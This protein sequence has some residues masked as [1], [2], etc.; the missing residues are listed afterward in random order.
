MSAAAAAQ[1]ASA[2]QRV[3]MHAQ[4]RLE[5]GHA[6]AV[7]T[8]NGG[9]ATANGHC[10]NGHAAIGELPP[11]PPPP[12]SAAS[13]SISSGSEL[14]ENGGCGH[15]VAAVA[16]ALGQTHLGGGGCCH[17][18]SIVN[19][20]PSGSGCGSTELPNGSS[21]TLN[22]GS[23]AH[24]AAE[25][26]GNLIIANGTSS[27]SG[28]SSS[29]RNQVESAAPVL[30]ATTQAAAAAYWSTAALAQQNGVLPPR[31]HSIY[32]QQHPEMLN[33][34]A[35]SGSGISITAVTIDDQMKHVDRIAKVSV[36]LRWPQGT[37]AGQC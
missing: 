18:G 3:T 2:A 30:S 16:A 26:C 31:K 20:H 19:G 13:G 5:N 25:H 6:A 15:G 32:A 1:Q 35:A 27:S 36:Q 12:A 28:S 7:A 9:M 33:G 11:L 4:Q 10:G 22:G 17:N 21:A 37:T 29:G 34:S 23:A 8:T 14:E 24:A